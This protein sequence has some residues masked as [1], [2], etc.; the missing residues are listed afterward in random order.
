MI[1]PMECWN[2]LDNETKSKICKEV[3]NGLFQVA[4]IV[5]AFGTGKKIEK[6]YNIN[7]PQPEEETKKQQKKFWKK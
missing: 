1:N 4:A 7:Q 5:A 2:K 3:T 6:H